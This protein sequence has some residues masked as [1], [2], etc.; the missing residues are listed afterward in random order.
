MKAGEGGK[1]PR[2]KAHIVVKGFQQRNFVDFDE[3][4]TPIVKM[5]SIL[6]VLSIATSMDLEIEQM[7]VKIE[8]FHGELDE[9]IYIQQLE[10]FVG[11]GKENLAC[12]LKK[13]IYD[14]KQAPH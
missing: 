8:F 7:D 1:T 9:E 12:Q 6:I 2:Y 13:S 5:T 3:S 11:K 10:D 14:L 4:F